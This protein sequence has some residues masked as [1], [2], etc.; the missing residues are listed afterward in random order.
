MIS[1]D[2]KILQNVETIDNSQNVN[3]VELNIKEEPLDELL[4]EAE[5][6]CSSYYQIN[7]L[8]NLKFILLL[9]Y[10]N[11]RNTQILNDDSRNDDN[12]ND[13]DNDFLSL[14]GFSGVR[15][16]SKFHLLI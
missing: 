16:F 2:I 10:Y 13:Q 7:K 5:R 9:Y 1:T 15:K 12:C 6:Y 4:A 11:F 3:G 8:N 14:E